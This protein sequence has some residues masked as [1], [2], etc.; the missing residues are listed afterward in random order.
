LIV[1]FAEL[2]AFL[3]IVLAARVVFVVQKPFESIRS[4]FSYI[5]TDSNESKLA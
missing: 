3:L 4:W 2:V 5:F 1:N